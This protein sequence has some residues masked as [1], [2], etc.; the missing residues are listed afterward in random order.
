MH[1]LFTLRDS[2]IFPGREVPTD[3]VWRDRRT[4]KVVIFND[5][6]EVALL[7]NTANEYLELPGG[8]VWDNETLTEGAVRECEEETGCIVEIIGELGCTDDYRS[9]DTRH[10]INFGFTA[11]VVSHEGKVDLTDD[12]KT[13][14]KQLRWVATNEAVIILQK[15]EELLRDNK[16]GFYNTAFNMIRDSHFLQKAAKN[17]Y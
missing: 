7:G 13:A 4:V 8:G 10:N 14:G 3:I 6:G 16:V 17:I 2:D 11:K 12:E 1:P 15:Q 5:S 9:R